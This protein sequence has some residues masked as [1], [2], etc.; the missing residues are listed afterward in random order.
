MKKPV[1][2][3]DYSTDAKS[4][5]NIS[6]WFSSPVSVKRICSDR[7]FPG[8][9]PREYRAVIHSGSALTIVEDYPFVSGAGDFIGN[10]T[11]EGIPQM[12]ICYGHQLL[13]RI[14][15][16]RDSVARCSSVEI[17]WLPVEFLP[18]WPVHGLS[19]HLNVW[20]SHYDSVVKLPRG[21]VVTATNSHT[22]IQ[23]FYNGD[24][25][26][27]GTQFHPEFD[28]ESGNRCFRDDPEIFAV[29]GIDME[30]TLQRGPDFNT[31]EVVFSHFLKAF[32][33]E[34]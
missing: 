27:F 4:G 9:I 14:L 13:A 25:K 21:S 20:Q 24:L 5:G 32:E 26:L 7:A 15:S 34:L 29:N 28:R 1:L 22:A 8:L 30:K 33:Q 3:L 10:C 17:G 2:V 23:G 16:G 31:G 11:T 6:R 12:G 19:G 18:A